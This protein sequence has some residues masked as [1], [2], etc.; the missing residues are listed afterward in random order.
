MDFTKIDDFAADADREVGR[1]RLEFSLSPD[2]LL[3]S[4]FELE[5]LKWQSV[6]YLDEDGINE[7]P[8]DR[9]G[10]YAFAICG[11]NAVLPHNSYVLYVGIAGRKSNRSLRARYRDYFSISKVL[12]RAKVAMMISK[13]RSVL[14]FHFAPIEN[15]ITSDQLETLEEQLNGALMPPM[16]TG[17]LAA[18]LKRKRRAF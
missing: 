3:T 9:R 5:E 6:A 1:F 8:D 14:H 12:P 18:D 2:R 17:D 11:D 15:D 10:I 7:V 13:W 16:S 4:P